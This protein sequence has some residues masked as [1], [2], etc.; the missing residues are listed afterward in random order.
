[1]ER[2]RNIFWVGRFWTYLAR[3]IVPCGI[4]FALYPAYS[5]I[6]LNPGL[7]ASGFC[8]IG[9]A[10]HPGEHGPDLPLRPHEKGRGQHSYNELRHSLGRSRLVLEY[11]QLAIIRQHPAV[12]LDIRELAQGPTP[13][14]ICESS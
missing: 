6:S 10:L 11:F 5:L 1:M 3:E 14:D 4:T 13:R 7:F 9:A 2:F 12:G 8:R